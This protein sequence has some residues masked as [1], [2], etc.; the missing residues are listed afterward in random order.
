[1]KYFVFSDV[2]GE[3]NAMKKGL[4]E[5]AYDPQNE[6]HQIISLGDYFG[7]AT[8]KSSSKDVF[9]YLTSNIH[10]NKPICI[11]GN[12]EDILLN[13][14]KRGKLSTTDIYNGEHK[15]I[16]SFNNTDAQ[17]VF[18]DPTGVF[19]NN[20]QKILEPWIR[21]LPFYF[22]TKNYRFTHGFWPL[23]ERNLMV[24]DPENVE[25]SEWLRC[26][27][28]DTPSNIHLYEHGLK[29]AAREPDKTLVFGHWHA[30]QLHETF[31]DGK[32]GDVIWRNERL[33]LIGV[34]QRTVFSHHIEVLVIE[35]EIS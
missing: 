28:S 16:A 15:T 19:I 3:F 2:H 14:F 31:P 6:N 22:E 17:T 25:R 11:F 1:M 35:D 12:H 27:W 18:F 7:R 9:N 33:K 26:T 23:D 4:D 20:T 10:K 24:D 30:F 29:A 34:D 32:I 5:A 21:T 13:T 8:V